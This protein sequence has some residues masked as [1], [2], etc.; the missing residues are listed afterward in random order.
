MSVR[1]CDVVAGGE[2]SATLGGSVCTLIHDAENRLQQ[3]Q[4]GSTVLA[5]YTVRQAQGGPY[6]ADG[7]RV[8]TVLGAARRADSCHE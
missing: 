6:D 1:V 4:Q 7:N 8:K 3:V 2:R 5:S